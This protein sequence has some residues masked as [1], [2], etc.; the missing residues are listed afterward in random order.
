L[1]LHGELD[2]RSRKDLASLD[3]LLANAYMQGVTLKKRLNGLKDYYPI[4]GDVPGKGLMLALEI[5]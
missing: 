5:V 2:E 3:A 4:I 1:S